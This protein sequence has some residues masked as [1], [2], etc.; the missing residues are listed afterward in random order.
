M[1]IIL[2]ISSYDAD[3]HRAAINKD[4]I[5]PHP[6]SSGKTNLLTFLYQ[7]ERRN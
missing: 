3:L 5:N 7:V 2:S 6:L 4:V 1:Q